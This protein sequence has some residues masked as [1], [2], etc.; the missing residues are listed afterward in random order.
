FTTSGNPI[1]IGITV[2]PAKVRL[3]PSLRATTCS[4]RARL[5]GATVI[6]ISI[7]F[8]EVVN[9]LQDLAN[10]GAGAQTMLTRRI[11][12]LTEI[13][14][15]PGPVAGSFSSDRA[16]ITHSGNPYFTAYVEPSAL[17]TGS[18]FF[19]GFCEEGA[20]TAYPGGLRTGSCTTGADCNPGQ[21]CLSQT[22][23][24]PCLEDSDCNGQA[25]CI[26]GR[27]ANY[28]LQVDT[29]FLFENCDPEP[30]NI[31]DNSLVPCRSAGWP[32]ESQYAQFYGDLSSDAA[33]SATTSCAGEN[34]ICCGVDFGIAD[35]D[36]FNNQCRVAACTPAGTFEADGEVGMASCYIG[37]DGQSLGDSLTD[38][39][40]DVLSCT[41]ELEVTQAIENQGVV[42]LD[43]DPLPNSAWRVTSPNSIEIID[44]PDSTSDFCD[45]LKDGNPHFVNVEIDSCFLIGG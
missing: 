39:L 5:A 18:G 20:L 24:S 11:P 41:V 8:P 22:C 10:V 25:L 15:Y 26:D 29:E 17:N 2:A 27:C 33:C 31:F 32:D 12:E 42:F 21:R 9:H 36:G 1:E 40:N 28:P 19:G 14:T 45:V 13:G 38:I 23:V 4:R 7:G 44:D 37:N 43:D 6:P 3:P 16:T 35:C 30:N 34:E